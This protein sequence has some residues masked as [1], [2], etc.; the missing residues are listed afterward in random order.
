MVE[1]QPGESLRVGGSKGH[2]YEA[3]VTGSEHQGTFT[4]CRVEHAQHVVDQNLDRG[5]IG[6]REPLGTPETAAVDDDTGERSRNTR[7][8][9]VLPVENDVR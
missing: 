1:D 6:G 8:R 9:R 3:A 5:D 2:R 7:K 4:P